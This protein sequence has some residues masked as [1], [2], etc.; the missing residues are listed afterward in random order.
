MSEHNKHGHSTAT[1]D[2]NGDVVNI[3]GTITEAQPARPYVPRETNPKH[4]KRD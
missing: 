4:A 1:T 3:R 2:S